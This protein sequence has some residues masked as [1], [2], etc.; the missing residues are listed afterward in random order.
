M[1]QLKGAHRR[2]S[3]QRFGKRFE[4]QRGRF[5]QVEKRFFLGR[6]L[7]GSTD[8]GTLRDQ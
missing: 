1:R 7:A 4:I 6:A 3:G 2:G 5:A 8:F